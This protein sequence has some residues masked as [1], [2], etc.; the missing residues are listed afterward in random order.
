MPKLWDETIESHRQAVRDAILDATAELVAAEGLRAVTMSEVA[1]R[2]GI[3][4]ATLY[5]YFAD[6]DA[7]LAAWHERQVGAHLE[8]LVAAR[9]GARGPIGRLEAVLAAY[10]L[11]GHEHDGELAALLHRAEHVH[12]AQ[13]QLHELVRDLVAEGATSGDLRDDV[14][15]AE[16]ARFCL[17]AI[18]A[19]RGASPK[20]L[21]RLVSVIVAG[22][23]PQ[24][25]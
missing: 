20:V 23:R 9:D 1:A 25:G 15:P 17:H 10:A 7:V 16:L 19:G 11:S 4:R 13:H 12:R 24:P 6:A 14:P 18:G 21:R 8:Q 3:G 22:L 5:K 2:T